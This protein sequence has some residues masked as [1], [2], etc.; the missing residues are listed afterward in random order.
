M[1]N[2]EHICHK[3]QRSGEH[4]ALDKGHRTT[5]MLCNW[6]LH[7]LR[8][9]KTHTGHSL[10]NDREI[11]GDWHEHDDWKSIVQ[12]VDDVIQESSNIDWKYKNLFS[13]SDLERENE[14]SPDLNTTENEK[15]TSLLQKFREYLVN[16]QESQ[17]I[18]S[19][20]YTFAALIKVMGQATS[21]SVFALLYV[22]INI[23]PIA[24]LFLHNIRIH[25]CP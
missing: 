5:R 8:C 15:K 21:R 10:I 9:T 7:P 2:A 23:A 11:C 6:C 3:Q 12:L 14:W 17:G 19:T 24:E 13:M 25:L 22:I 16:Y 18:P 1:H 4:C 20:E